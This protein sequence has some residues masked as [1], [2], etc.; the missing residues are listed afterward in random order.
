MRSNDATGHAI[1]PYKKNEQIPRSVVNA[2]LSLAETAG[3]AVAAI[4]VMAFV[5][6]VLVALAR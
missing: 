1:G 6:L 2:P 4:V 3:V 5:V